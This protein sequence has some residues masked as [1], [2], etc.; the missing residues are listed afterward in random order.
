MWIYHIAIIKCMWQIKS[1]SR[2]DF[3]NLGYFSTVWKRAFYF[4]G[5]SWK[6]GAWL[7]RGFLKRIK[8]N[9]KVNFS[10]QHH[11]PLLQFVCTSPYHFLFP[12][13][14]PCHDLHMYLHPLATYHTRLENKVYTYQELNSQPLAQKSTI[15]STW[16]SKQSL[17]WRE[18]FALLLL[19]GSRLPTAKVLIY[20]YMCTDLSSETLI[21]KWPHIQIKQYFTR[22]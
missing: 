17:Q 18:Y 1:E 21:S 8:C 11:P 6:I 9:C 7:F 19:T 16:P 5:C 20:L 4:W 14:L 15:I 2:L 22:N 3:N 12:L 10:H 13:T